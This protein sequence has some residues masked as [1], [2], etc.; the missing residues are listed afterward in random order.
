MQAAKDT[1]VSF[2]Y[3]VAEPG[4]AELESS[5]ERGEP[6]AVLM[7]HGGIIPG[8]EEALIGRSAGEAFEV[9]VPAD[10]AYGPL[11]ANFTQRVPKKYFRDAARLRPG[12]QTVVKTDQ[13]PRLVTVL[14][15]GIS[16][17]D[18]DLNHPLAGRTLVFNVEVVDVRAATDEERSHGHAHGAGGHQHD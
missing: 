5:H 13:G 10:K 17:V 3:R 2:H 15:V 11:R 1:V 7:G 8:L 4:S 16:V 14:K 18:V 12:V 6:L 9:E